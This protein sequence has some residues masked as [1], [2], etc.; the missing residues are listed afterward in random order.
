MLLNVCSKK[1]KKSCVF[2]SFCLYI[3]NSIAFTLN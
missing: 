1:E 3:E 2:L